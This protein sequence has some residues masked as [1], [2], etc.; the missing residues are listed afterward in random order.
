MDTG[1]VSISKRCEIT[2][3]DLREAYVFSGLRNDHFGYVKAIETPAILIGLRNTAI[4][5]KVKQMQL[6]LRGEAK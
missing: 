3:D 6:N 4:A 1:V 2:A 5:R